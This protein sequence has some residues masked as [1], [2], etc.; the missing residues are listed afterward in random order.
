VTEYQSPQIPATKEEVKIREEESSSI[1]ALFLVSEYPEIA[2]R[3]EGNEL[4][5]QLAAERH[6]PDQSRGFLKTA[7]QR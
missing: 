4:K 3:S 1:S 7:P 2:N 6:L 5:K